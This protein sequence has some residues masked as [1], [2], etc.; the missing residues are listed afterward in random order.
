L[1]SANVR[2]GEAAAD[3]AAGLPCARAAGAPLPRNAVVAA[4]IASAAGWSFRIAATLSRIDRRSTARA[5]RLHLRRSPR[6]PARC[7]WRCAGPA[8]LERIAGALAAR[9]GGL[10]R[11]R[12][13]LLAGAIEERDGQAVELGVGRL[14][15]DL[16]DDLHVGVATDPLRDRLPQRLPLL[17]LGGRE[18]LDP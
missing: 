5:A 2:R 3:A 9:L 8:G 6:D 12:R 7:A 14:G 1:S 18:H 17:G 15:H 13:A 11:R 4:A 16:V 10:G